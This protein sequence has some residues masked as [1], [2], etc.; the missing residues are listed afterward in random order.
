MIKKEILLKYEWFTNNEYLD[1]YCELINKNITRSYEKFKTQKH[2][3]IPIHCYKYKITHDLSSKDHDYSFYKKLADNDI[4]NY[5]VNLLYPDH[6]LAHYYLSLCTEGQIKFA[7]QN[8]VFHVLGNI[9]FL[10]D[11]SYKITYEKLSLIM[12]KLEDIKKDLSNEKS[13]RYKGHNYHGPI[14]EKQKKQ[15]SEANGGKTYIRKLINGEVIVKAIKGNE[16]IEKYLSDGWELGNNYSSK[17]EVIGKNI[18]RRKKGAI[19][20]NN[21]Q[22]NRYVPK[23]EIESYL[24]K[25]WLKGWIKDC[26]ERV[27]VQKLNRKIKIEKSQLNSYTNRGWMVID[28]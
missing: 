21:G 6:V 4:N 18:S 14:S 24:E 9:N 27:W 19:C 26:I 22:R 16:L 25:G 3:I 28:D 1:K 2:H 11:D 15:I 20:I 23:E 5:T 12:D 10:K 13:K 7:N 8:A 17:K